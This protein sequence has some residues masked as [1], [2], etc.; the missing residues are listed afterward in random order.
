MKSE[1][2]NLIDM[3]KKD[4]KKLNKSDLIKLLLKQEMKKYEII[5]DKKPKKKQKVI[6]VNEKKRDIDGQS[7]NIDSKYQNLMSETDQ[8]VDDT[9]STQKIRDYPM[10]EKTLGD[11]RRSEMRMSTEKK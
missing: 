1:K 9:V 5:V 11:F 4:L 8:R 2:S 10:T 3:N 7:F 6:K